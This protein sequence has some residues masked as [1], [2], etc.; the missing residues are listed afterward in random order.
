MHF[1]RNIHN[2]AKY[3]AEKMMK[4]SVVTNGDKKD[5]SYDKFY[6]QC[7]KEELLKVEQLQKE[8][9]MV[10]VDLI[11]ISNK[12]LDDD[13]KD[14]WTD[15]MMEYYMMRCEEIKSDIINGH[16]CDMESSAAIDEVEEDKS[17]SASFMTQDEVSEKVESSMAQMQGGVASH[18]SNLQ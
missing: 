7:Y 3:N 2:S 11:L 16:A 13:L 17:G 6:S 8:R 1:N 4:N 5:V 9:G 15:E 18:P 12:P 10:E 14:I